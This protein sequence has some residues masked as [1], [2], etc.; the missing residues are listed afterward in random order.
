MAQGRCLLL[1]FSFAAVL[2]L[3]SCAKV[4]PIDGASVT[5]AS[6]FNVKPSPVVPQDFTTATLVDDTAKTPTV[7]LPLPATSELKTEIPS[8]AKIQ[9]APAIKAE[10][11][12]I[13]PITLTI[14]PTLLTPIRIVPSTEVTEEMI[15][16]SSVVKISPSETYDVPAVDLLPPK[17]P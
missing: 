8:W 11:H 3:V 17:K 9:S 15:A 10:P 12:T 4:L 16:P 5:L 1:V 2:C 13:I 6:G 7:P 14:T